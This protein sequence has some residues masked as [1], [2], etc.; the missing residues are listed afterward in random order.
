M[1][2]LESGHEGSVPRT[3][4][5]WDG[6]R[7]SSPGGEHFGDGGGT[8]GLRLI[9]LPLP[10]L[11]P[12]NLLP[13]ALPPCSH[14]PIGSLSRTSHRRRPS[15]KYSLKYRRHSQTSPHLTRQTQRH[16]P[17]ASYP[18]TQGLSSALPCATPEEL[19]RSM[20]AEQDDPAR[21]PASA[22][23]ADE[24]SSPPAK[25]AAQPKRTVCD[26]CRRRSMLLPSLVLSVPSLIDI[27]S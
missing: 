5:R 10:L 26:H 13:T 2:H 4:A 14:S 6:V 21:N 12:A 27:M 23:D 16:T 8:S 11:N 1:S 18:T 19:L 9:Q 25:K 22:A 3:L 24:G 7:A 15:L 17:T 20:K